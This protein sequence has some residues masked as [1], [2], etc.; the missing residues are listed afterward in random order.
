MSYNQLSNNHFGANIHITSINYFLPC[1]EQIACSRKGLRSTYLKY[2]Y[3]ILYLPKY[4]IERYFLSF[5]FKNGLTFK[6]LLLN[7]FKSDFMI[8]IHK[9]RNHRFW[10]IIAITILE[11]I[12]VLVDILKLKN[13]TLFTQL[14]HARMNGIP[15]VFFPW[16]SVMIISHVGCGASNFL[17]RCH[18]FRIGVRLH[19]KKRP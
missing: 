10:K 3:L 7:H 4:K 16:T 13:I 19:R 5:K 15:S 1:I 9:D 6:L 11:F 14:S 18:N 12:Q 2:I 17:K 8:H